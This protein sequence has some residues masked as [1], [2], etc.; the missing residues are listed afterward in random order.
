MFFA[1]SKHLKIILIFNFTASSTHVGQKFQKA[2]RKMEDQLN[3]IG[4]GKGKKKDGVMEEAPGSR[5]F[6][7]KNLI[8]SVLF[9]IELFHQI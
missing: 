1:A 6:L 9:L 4:L 2:K 7:L 3:K 8:K 5:K